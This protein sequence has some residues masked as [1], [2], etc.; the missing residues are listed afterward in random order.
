MNIAKVET[1]RDY[2]NTFLEL[3]EM[4]KV[5]KSVNLKDCMREKY[6][7]ENELYDGFYLLERKYNI[8]G[9]ENWSVENLWDDEFNNPFEFEREM[10]KEISTLNGIECLHIE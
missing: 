4:Q 8:N 5:V 3:E 2:W 10:I 1:L 6:D 7:M 9:D